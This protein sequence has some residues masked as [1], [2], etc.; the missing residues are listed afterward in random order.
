ME[1]RRIVTG[2]TS[3]EVSMPVSDGRPPLLRVPGSDPGVQVTEFWRDEGLPPELR[4]RTDPVVATAATGPLERGFTWRTVELDAGASTGAADGD[5]LELVVLLEGQALL[6]LG[7][8]ERAVSP[9]DCVVLQ[10]TGARWTN[11]GQGICVMSVLTVAAP[12]T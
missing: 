12:R 11:P 6:T 10:G 8:D 7:D 2:E 5:R 9:G 3:R 1:L 4:G